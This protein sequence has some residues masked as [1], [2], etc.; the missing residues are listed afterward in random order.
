[1]LLTPI[2]KIS[3]SKKA[4]IL[5]WHVQE[6]MIELSTVAIWEVSTTYK[7]MNSCIHTEAQM[8]AG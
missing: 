5:Y 6:F 7:I 1:M 3:H 8:Y 2:N 4:L